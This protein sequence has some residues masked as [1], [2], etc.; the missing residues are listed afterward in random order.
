MEVE[1]LFQT[2]IFFLRIQKMMI[3][4]Q[5]RFKKGNHIILMNKKS[6]ITNLER[7]LKLIIEIRNMRKIL[8]LKILI[9]K[10]MVYQITL[11]IYQVLFNKV[12]QIQLNYKEIKKLGSQVWKKIKLYHKAYI[13]IYTNYKAKNLK[14]RVSQKTNFKVIGIIL[15]QLNQN[16][17]TQ[18]LTRIIKGNKQAREYLEQVYLRIDLKLQD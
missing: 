13:K 2:E 18:V 7:K 4:I 10:I 16:F 5:T 1:D 6:I 9:N 8:V 14:Q 17:L 12:C 3:K 11:V 15:T